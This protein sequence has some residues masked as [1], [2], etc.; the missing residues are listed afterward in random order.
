MKVVG[1]S[2]NKLKETTFDFLRGIYLTGGILFIYTYIEL[3]IIADSN[4]FLLYPT[5]VFFAILGIIALSLKFDYGVKND[6][7]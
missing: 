3:F 2:S 5:A 4:P 7:K 1:L 6:N